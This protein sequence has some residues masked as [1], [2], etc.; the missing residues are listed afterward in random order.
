MKRSLDFWENEFTYCLG[1]ATSH[2][3][4]R[5]MQDFNHD[6][7]CFRHYC[8]VQSNN[9]FKDGFAT[10]ANDFNLLAE[11]AEGRSKEAAE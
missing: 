1:I 4:A 8:V 9:C 2:I 5:R 7:Q 6:W 3:K 11:S 10:L